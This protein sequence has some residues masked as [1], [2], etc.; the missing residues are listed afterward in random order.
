MK[1]LKAGRNQ[2]PK[3]PAA[4]GTGVGGFKSEIQAHWGH[5]ASLGVVCAIVIGFLTWNAEPGGF[6]Y[7]NSGPENAYYNLLVQGFRAGQLNL[8]T[9][10]PPGLAQLPD[11]PILGVNLPYHWF[12]GHPLL[13]LSCYQGKFYLYF[14]VTPALVLFWPYATLTGHYLSHK[15]AGLI[16]CAMG[17][18]A[19]VGLL[20]ALWRRC[21]SE[22][23]FGVVLAGAVALG[24][25]TGLP[26]LM[27]RCEV[28]EVAVSCGYAF[29]MLALAA[30][31]GA[32]AQPQLQNR[33]LALASLAYG[34]ALGARPDLLF[35]AVILL[36][37]V[38]LAWRRRQRFLGLLLAAAGPIV[39]IGLGL[40]LYN[41]LR[42]GN[43][44]EFGQRYQLGDRHAIIQHFSL[45]Y[46]WFNFRVY[47]LEPV[48]WIGSFPFVRGVALPPAPAGHGAVEFAFSVLTGVPLV[49]LGLA[50]LLAWR[51]QP[52][53]A[54]S[55]LRGFL[56]AA[57][58]LGAT[59]A[60][61]LCL[62]HWVADRYEVEFLPALVLLAMAGVCCLERELVA[63]PRWRQVARW[64]WALLLALSVGFNLLH[65]VE[66]RALAHKE[67][68]TVL[69]YN[70]Q[71]GEAIHQY[72]EAIRL[73]P[74]YDEAHY[75]LGLAF[76][77]TGQ[78]DEA[79]RQYQEALRLNPDY[80]E[81]HYDLGVALDR[82][83][84]IDEAISQYQEALHLNSGLAK[85]HG[86][87]G[88]ALAGKGQ[89]DQATSEYQEALRLSPDLTVIHYDLGIALL[90]KGQL[91]EAIRQFQET[92]RLRPD[93][94]E[95]HLNLGIGLF[96]E[97]QLDEAISQYQEAIRLKPDLVE[98]YNNLGVALLKKGQLDEAIGQFQEAIRLKPD[99]TDAQKNLAQALE[100][101]N[102]PAGR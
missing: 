73:K 27:S 87:L 46:L 28:Y 76:F 18:L 85:A 40:M 37:P 4:S 99:D 33:W 79:I 66:R 22:V 68:G 74:D 91:D 93:L 69:E 2:R 97:G 15:D 86:A 64:C 26:L 14:G 10:V 92:I 101:K 84:Q 88:V 9:E 72:Q 47:F 21:F 19:S 38:V 82:K 70:G 24:L 83:G 5:Y 17:F 49:W 96:N 1:P 44:L 36:I 20:Y 78:M 90:N 67:S 12:D 54:R 89:M 80:A 29:A 61:L 52:E 77:R 102:A 42:F 56:V 50:T 45:R 7:L 32:Q 63:Q 41:A 25:A 60:L 71:T 3:P 35:G 8:K 98:V 55:V 75:N 34:M 62:Y 95:A 48:H 39:V 30:V 94:A 100:K 6:D 53:A 51:N 81:A 11:P 65:A 16:F 13:D 43:P 57:G 58:W 23:G 31:W 59:S